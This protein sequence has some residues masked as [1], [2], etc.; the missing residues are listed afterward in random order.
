MV[1]REKHT[2][3]S[4]KGIQCHMAN[5][6]LAEVSNFWETERTGGEQIRD[7]PERHE[8]GEEDRNRERDFLT[9]LHWDNEHETRQQ[10][11]QSVR[12]DEYN[13]VE[14]VPTF[15]FQMDN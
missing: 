15:E 3:N 7:S 8:L 2:N 1:L 4:E 5:S 9:R 10:V 13:D 12:D 6:S 14:K 11:K